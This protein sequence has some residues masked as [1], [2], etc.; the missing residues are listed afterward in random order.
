VRSGVTRPVTGAGSGALKGSA[1]EGCEQS[2]RRCPRWPGGVDDAARRAARTG[3]VYVTDRGRVSYVLLS[4]EDY[5]RLAQNQASIVDLLAGP[6]G[7]ED[8]E[9]DVPTSPDIAAPAGFD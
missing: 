5:E 2:F 8:I 9:F 6:P 7:V 4:F 3:P 1:P